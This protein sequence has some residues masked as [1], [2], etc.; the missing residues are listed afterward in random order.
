M[1]LSLVTGT[2][3][4]R[5]HLARMVQSFRNCLPPGIAYEVV[6]VDG[7]SI[8]GTLD[9]CKQQADVRLIEQGALLGAIRAFDAG[10]EAAAGDY[11]ILANDDILFEP[12]S[13]LP[14]LVHL[15]TNPLCGA[16]AFADNRPAP[17]YA[18]GYKVQ[19]ITVTNPQGKD[20]ALPYPQVGMIRRW[21][22]EAAGWW[23]STDAVMGSEGHTYGGDNYLGARIWELGYTVEAVEGCKI[24]DLVAPDTLRAINEAAERQNPGAYYKRY[25]HPPQQAAEPVVENP[26]DERLRVLYLPLYEPNFGHY[27][28]GLREALAARGLVYEIDYVNQHY[29]LPKAVRTFQPHLL[30]MQAHGHD[31]IPQQQLAEARAIA[32]EMLVVNWNGDVWTDGLTS[33]PMLQFLQHVDMALTVNSS[34][35]D[36]LRAAG[37]RAAYWQVAYEPVDETALPPV[38]Q[39][40]VVFLANAYSDARRELGQVLQNLAGVNVGLYGAGWKWGNGNTLYNFAIGRALYRR[41]KVAIGDNQYPEQVGFVSNRIFEALAAGVLLLHQHVPGLE[42]LTGLREGEHYLGWHDTAELQKLLHYWL[43]P[44][45]D[46]QRRAIAEAGRAFVQQR[47]SFEA[48]VDELFE[49]IIPMIEGERERN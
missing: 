22:G 48:R 19:T 38:P 34:A 12:N 49:R 15:E 13:I 17:G 25:P 16:V 45:R 14:A 31:S 28:R 9:W 46:D 20:V 39:H 27:K 3:N 8:D 6:V 4:R 30:L 24:R 7:G 36:D 26:Q 35:L 23:G 33:A 43:Q 41:A 44:R 18:A 42:A 5:A 37:I 47:H 21:L 1:I 40:D 2:Y 29:N 32:P 11:V 10:A